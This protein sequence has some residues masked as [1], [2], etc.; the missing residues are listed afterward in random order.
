MT[1]PSPE[2]SEPGGPA[3]QGFFTRGVEADRVR[4]E[5]ELARLRRRTLIFAT[6]AFLAMIA[7]VVFALQW[8]RA[9]ARRKD[10]ELARHQAEQS[11]KWK[12]RE[13]RRAEQ[14]EAAAQAAKE[15]AVAAKMAADELIRSLQYDLNA[16]LGKLGYLKMMDGMNERIRK[17]QD[18]HPPEEGDLSAWREQSLALD[19]RGDL[20]LAR[21]QP[22][23]AL[24][25]YRDALAI[26]ERLVKKEPDNTLWQG[27]LSRSYENV[28]DVLRAQG[29]LAEGLEGLPGLAR[30]Q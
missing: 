26:R 24:K 13:K 1:E 8:R 4:R 6:L 14:G 5:A 16:T 7:A 27:D 18:G 15:K 28:G 25:A 22:A 9:A 17:Y 3:K 10:A 21:G 2:R 29:Q 20:L 11:R 30:H 23:E 19:Q 12:E